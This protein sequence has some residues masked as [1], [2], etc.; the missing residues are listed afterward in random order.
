M[1]FGIK[2]LKL[3]VK[4]HETDFPTSGSLC[5]VRDVKK[6]ELDAENVS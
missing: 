6:V 1:D 4:I 3:E 5:H 2:Q